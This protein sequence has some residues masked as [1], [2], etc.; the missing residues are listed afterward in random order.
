MAYILLVEDDP[1]MQELLKTVIAGNGHE[2]TTADDG[3][4]ALVLI[5]NRFPQLVVTD[6]EMP[7]LDGPAMIYRLFIENLGRE[8]IPTILI[9]GNIDLPQIAEAIGTPYYL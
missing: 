9:S 4:E 6:V 1:D 3:M 7:R 8:N 2:V 5:D